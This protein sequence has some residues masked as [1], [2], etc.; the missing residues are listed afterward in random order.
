M[1]TAHTIKGLIESLNANA[2]TLQGGYAL[3]QFTGH[4]VTFEAGHVVRERR[5][6]SGR[7]VTLVVEYKD[8]TRMLYSWSEHRGAQ[9][10]AI[11]VAE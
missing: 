3:N 8:Y 4:R 11:G 2:V 10:E 9:Y 5:N 1:G 7:V 6:S